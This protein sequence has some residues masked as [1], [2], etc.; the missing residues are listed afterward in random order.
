[1]SNPIGNRTFNLL[2]ST[3]HSLQLDTQIY[4]RALLSSFLNLLRAALR[5]QIRQQ[6]FDAILLLECGQ[7]IF[8]IVGRDLRL[9]LAH[10]F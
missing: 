3:Q 8:K 7:T 6:L 9:G 10:S 2:R 5:F 4:R 1:M